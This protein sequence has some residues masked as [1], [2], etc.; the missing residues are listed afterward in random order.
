MTD[1][2]LGNR[3]SGTSNRV[4][5]GPHLEY[6]QKNII[7]P[8][9]DTG[10]SRAPSSIHIAHGFTTTTSSSLINYA[11]RKRHLAS[12]GYV[13]TKYGHNTITLDEVVSHD[14]NALG[15]DL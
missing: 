10:M 14:L 2:V 5:F 4:P 6:T 8:V 11:V 15:S 3:H 13:F 12:D 9:C 1:S 7:K